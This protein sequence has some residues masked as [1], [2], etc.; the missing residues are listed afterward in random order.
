MTHEEFDETRWSVNMKG[1]Y[2]GDIYPIVS[3]DFEERIVALDG[4][5]LGSDEPNWV[6]CENVTLV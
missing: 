4:V 6:R 2:R 5:T 1:E 3:C